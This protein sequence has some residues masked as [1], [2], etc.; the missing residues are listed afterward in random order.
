[1]LR[2]ERHY[3]D[4]LEIQSFLREEQQKILKKIRK[5]PQERFKLRHLC[6]ILKSCKS[7][8]E[9]GILRIFSLPYLW[10]DQG[11]LEQ[12]T[13][14]YVLYVEPAMGV[15]YHH[16][17]C[18]YF[19]TLKDPCIF[20]VGSEEDLAFV[21]SQ[22]R[23]EGV[24]LAHSDYLEDIPWKFSA[25]EKE[26]DIVFNATYDDMPRKRHELM[27]ELLE[28]PLLVNARVLFLGRGEQTN[29]EQL[30]KRV[31]QVGL[32]DRVTVLANLRRAD[33][34]AQLD[35][36]KMG[37]HL[38]VNENGCRG[39]YEF[40][41]SNLPCVISSCIA[42]TNLAIFN[43]QT[44]MAVPDKDLPEAIAF[45]LTHINDFEPRRWFLDHSGSVNSSQKLNEILKNLFSDW[46]YGWSEDIVPLGSSGAN[47]YVC[48]DDYERFRPDFQWL[49]NCFQRSDKWPVIFSVD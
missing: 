49:L 39:I 31:H 19:A 18:R 17:W 46:G 32:E 20:G 7:P 10:I 6:Q 24:P 16:G 25:K 15:I 5:K 41:R 9:K 3:G 2:V 26:Y 48:Q 1:M 44:G 42:G 23:V 30:K 8:G 34:P 45:V 37:V 28:H 11:L 38:S 43:S 35:R 14:K 33:V 12:L 47:R 40:F 22:S 13:Q 21:R 27:L 29:V 36:C 4:E